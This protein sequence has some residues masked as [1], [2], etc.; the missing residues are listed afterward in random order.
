MS[1][2][3]IA[4]VV[5]P[6]LMAA[7]MAMAMRHD[8][9]LQRVFSLAL[10]LTLIAIA[11]GLF[12]ATLDGTVHI[13]QL[14]DWVAPFGIVLVLDRLSA[15]ML[16]LTSLLSVGIVLYVMGSDWDRRGWHFHAL[17]AFQL[18]GVNGAFLTGDAFNLFVFFEVLLI[19]SYGLMIHAGGGM[20]LRAG[21]QYVVMNL[22]GSTLFLFAMGT[23]YAVTGTL[24]MADMAVKVQALDPGDQAL[25][26]TGG[27]LLAIVFGIKAA[28][29]PVQFWLI[30]TYSN[31]P[32]PVAAFFAIMT[33]VGAYA[34][35]RMYSLVF[36]PEAI[37]VD[38]FFHEMLMPAGLLTL[39]IGAVGVFGAKLLPRLAAFSV[40]ASMGTLLI[41]ISIG[42]PAGT[43]AALYYLVHSTFA[44]A[45]LFLVLDLV[46]D[47]QGPTT[48]APGGLVASL[49]FVA[50][51]A[52]C[53]MPP[54]SGFIGKLLVL[55]AARSDPLWPVV[56]VVILA[57]SLLLI[58]G[59]TL[60][61]SR[62]FWKP[63]DPDFANPANLD[64]DGNPVPA[65]P[66]R[67]LA[68]VGAC[69]PIGLLLLFTLG[70]GPAMEH[71]SQ[72][73]A[74]LFDTNAYIE[75]VLGPQEAH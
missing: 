5:L 38:T 66:I 21:L 50:A 13:Y 53:G 27:M 40:L 36:T 43:T 17:F 63:L 6:A 14:G 30:G 3:I 28:A 18:M 7:V 52:V 71:F 58:L 64:P 32:A 67:P 16:L 45:A 73:A 31:A 51:I 68:I 47:S 29:F 70:S 72:T 62:Y 41:A 69:V 60:R 39:L 61:G 56:W 65:H 2:W 75:A 48:R 42:T 11:G 9:V 4:P 26:R 10:S 12:I 19:A 54:L 35:L 23:L 37:A 24:N 55:D 33:K 1:H 49:F 57:S 22:A 46:A 8:V 74:Q 25:L 20:R 44:A 15:M 59:F 34:I